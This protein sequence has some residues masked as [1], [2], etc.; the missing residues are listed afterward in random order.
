[1]PKSD[2]KPADELDLNKF[3]KMEEINIR[4]AS[5]E[6]AGQIRD[7][8]AYYVLHTAITYEYE[9]PSLEEMRERIA[10]TLRKFP[11]LTAEQEGEILGYAYAGPFKQRAAYDWSVES[12][13]YV[14]R[15]A[16]GRGIGKRLL[17][18][19]EGILKAQKIL[20]VNACIAVP[21]EREDR[22]LTFDSVRFHEKMG[23]QAVG[24]FH[25]CACKFN[26]WYDMIWME[27]ML[28]DHAVPPAP[29]VPF[30]QLETE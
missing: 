7:L 13:I 20:N 19:L 18:S 11:Y 2:W 5:P 30:P 6:D 28:G 29:F 4:T 9:V 10:H 21:G 23:Y 17:V 14:S 24:T 22:Y 27:K 25:K 15:D 12:S 3:N 1:M 26:R 8:Y 16:R